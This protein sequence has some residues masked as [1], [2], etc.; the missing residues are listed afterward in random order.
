MQFLN[1]SKPRK[2]KKKGQKERRQKQS[3]YKKLNQQFN[4]VKERE[5]AEKRKAK[6]GSES[7]PDGQDSVITELGNLIEEGQVFKNRRKAMR[8]GITYST[9]S[10]YS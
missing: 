2:R 4:F 5:M 9:F 1:W 3:G 7:V 8:K 6:Y 10:Y